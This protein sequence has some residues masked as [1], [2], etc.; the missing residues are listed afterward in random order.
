MLSACVINS[1][2]PSTLPRGA[3]VATQGMRQL[4]AGDRDRAR[5]SYAEAF[6]QANSWQCWTNLAA[7][8]LGL[9]DFEAALAN[10]RKAIGID[11]GHADTW[12]NAGV[13]SWRKG[14]RKDGARL[15]AHALQL[16]PAHATA[17]INYSYMLR[18]VERIREAHEVLAGARSRGARS[19]WVLRAMAELDR[20]LERSDEC[21]ANALEALR[22]LA[23]NP[24]PP[25][26]PGKPSAHLAFDAATWRGVLADCLRRLAPLR[27]DPCLA[28][29]AVRMFALEGGLPVARKD[30]D[31]VIDARVSHDLLRQAFAQGYRPFSRQGQL[32]PGKGGIGVLGLV[33]EASN[34][35]IDLMLQD[36]GNGRWRGSFGAPD[37]LVF[38]TPAFSI[39][40]VACAGVEVPLPVPQPVHEYLSWIYG[41][42]W[43]QPTQAVA[44]HA[45]P[46]EYMQKGMH[47][48]GLAPG[49]RPAVLNRALLSLLSAL[50]GGWVE[51]AAALCSQILAMESIDEVQRVKSRLSQA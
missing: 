23:G 31:I 16:V 33:H 41:D 29:G 4:Q 27:C 39:E 42:D 35:P 24:W 50:H 9:E 10:A 38:D 7:L 25:P 8:A 12:V 3:H 45:V 21:R 40:S 47:C 5:R 26:I 30:I 17:A 43:R 11:P 46:R 28:G 22:I 36:R 6:T 34:I 48:R 14:A 51:M 44:G 20:I 1:A 32:V 13:A 2:A 49:S 15:M 19:P 18:T 37:H